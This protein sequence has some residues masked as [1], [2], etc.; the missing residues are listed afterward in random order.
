MDDSQYE[1]NLLE[2]V[3]KKKIAVPLE[4][5]K[6]SLLFQEL[7]KTINDLITNNEPINAVN[8]YKLSKNAQV[9][10]LYM[11]YMNVLDRPN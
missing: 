6:G 11:Q 7:I 8:I 2:Y 5:L 1:L 9:L 3:I 4:Q 10:V